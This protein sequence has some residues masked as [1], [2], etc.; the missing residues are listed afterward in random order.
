MTG[1]IYIECQWA[2]AGCLWSHDS[3]ENPDI[4]LTG[5]GSGGREPSLLILQAL[6]L[7]A[8]LLLT[9]T[10]LINTDGNLGDFLCLVLSKLLCVKKELLKGEVTGSEITFWPVGLIVTVWP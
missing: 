4:P 10:L 5:T 9:S 8:G 3:V 2:A 6:P 1:F 7:P